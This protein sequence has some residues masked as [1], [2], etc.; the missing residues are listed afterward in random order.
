MFVL[1]FIAEIIYLKLVPI[2]PFSDMK[3]VVQI[4]TSGFK[5]GMEYIYV[6]PNNLP[7]ATIF[8]FLFK[9]YNGVMVVKITNIV[10]NM[11]IIYFAYKTYKNIYKK[12]NRL[13][14]LFGI[15]SISTFLYV[16][17][18]YNDVMYV[19]LTTVILYI[20]TKKELVKKD[21]ILLA[22]LSFLQFLIRPVGIILIIAISMYLILKKYDY[23]TVIVIIATFILCNL[24]YIP[25]KNYFIPKSEEKLKYPIW[26]FLQM[27]INEAEFGFQDSSH[28]VDWTFGDVTSRIKELGVKRL[29]KLLAKKEYWLW[30]EGTY[31]VERYAFGAGQEDTFYYET[32]LTNKLLNPETSKIRKAL[33]YLMKAQYFVLIGLSLIS[34]IKKDENGKKDL[35]LYFIIGMFCFYLVWEMKSRYIYCLQPVFWIFAARGLEQI[36]AKIHTRKMI[37][38]KSKNNEEGEEA[39]GKI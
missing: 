10:C 33:D 26:S 25:V 5:E 22:L 8:Y 7:I 11:L 1:Y 36:Q 6:Y 12:K 27:G 17:H 34:L 30:T 29:T 35:L 14:L 28:S 32:P 23:K 15:F 9:I 2:K 21:I 3:S 4:A 37:S 19:A 13:V 24:I 39:D 18:V 20:T 38:D 16:N 31:Q